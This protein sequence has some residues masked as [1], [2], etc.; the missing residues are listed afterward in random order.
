MLYNESKHNI[1]AL[2]GKANKA[3]K[4]VYFCASPPF[5]DSSIVFKC[6]IQSTNGTP[7]FCVLSSAST[8]LLLEFFKIFD[9][10]NIANIRYKTNL[11]AFS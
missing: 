5:S 8:H 2:V 11:G 6:M 9:A 10:S 1:L 7:A 3:A 4:R